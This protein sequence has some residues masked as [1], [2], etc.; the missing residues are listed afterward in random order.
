MPGDNVDIG[1][2]VGEQMFGEQ[3]PNI[4]D[5][6]HDFSYSTGNGRH[7]VLGEMARYPA[8]YFTPQKEAYYSIGYHSDEMTVI[9]PAKK[10]NQYLKT[11][12]LDK[13]IQYREQHNQLD[14]S[15]E[16]IFS[17]CA[18]TLLKVGEKQSLDFTQEIFNYP[19]EI[20]PLNNPYT[21]N[22][23]ENLT[24][25]VDYLNKALTGA[26]IIA[27]TKEHPS[28]KQLIRTDKNGHANIL[29]N[30]SGTWLIKSVEMIKSKRIG[31][32][33]ESFWASLTFKI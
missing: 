30:K 31:V 27:F 7:K 16:E 5:N 3:Q 15:A 17:R 20:T 28:D 8:G 21:L 11:E 25:K 4:P 10:F 23:G 24:I 9:L 29:L 18:K 2:F 33:W 19:Y 12:G 32:D 26:L 14:H 13:I 22:I 6:Y 1:V